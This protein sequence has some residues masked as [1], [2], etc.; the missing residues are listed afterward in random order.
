MI[1][2]QSNGGKN[3]KRYLLSKFTL[4]NIKRGGGGEMCSN[5]TFTIYQPKIVIIAFNEVLF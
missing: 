2:F 3:F 1:I 4:R 5:Y